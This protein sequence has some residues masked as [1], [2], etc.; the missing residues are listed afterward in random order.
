LIE[1]WLCLVIPFFSI[2]SIDQEELL[3]SAGQLTA[4]VELQQQQQQQ[5]VLQQQQQ[6][7]EQG[8][9]FHLFFLFKTCAS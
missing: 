9:R 3:Q 5:L 6:L 4:I 2:E 7:R 1:F 8:A